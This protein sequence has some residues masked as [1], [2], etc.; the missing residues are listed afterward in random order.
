MAIR[1]VK[2]FY[3]LGGP[4]YIEAAYDLWAEYRRGKLVPEFVDDPQWMIDDMEN[5]KFAQKYD[6]KYHYELA[7]A[8]WSKVFDDDFEP[9]KEWFRD[10]VENH[11]SKEETA[12][13]AED[14]IRW[15]P[16]IEDWVDLWF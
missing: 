12:E 14:L 1:S 5:D 15:I 10:H 4:Q 11:A 6:R 9:F 7:A 13:F 8:L 3:K 16:G 2:E